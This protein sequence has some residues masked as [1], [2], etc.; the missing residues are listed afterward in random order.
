MLVTE[1]VLASR[2]RVEAVAF[3]NSLTS[4]RV[5][6]S[7]SLTE[8]TSS[9]SNVESSPVSDAMTRK[10]LVTADLFSSVTWRFSTVK[11]EP[12]TLPLVALTAT[13]AP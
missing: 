9:K 10:V 12:L 4:R 7:R 11:I 8:R 2:R 13:F 1:I 3:A 5:P 6:S